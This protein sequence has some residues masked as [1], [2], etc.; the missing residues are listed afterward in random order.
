MEHILLLRVVAAAHLQDRI[1]H[2]PNLLLGH[3]LAVVPICLSGV[4]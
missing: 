4:S 3:E 1:I 2:G